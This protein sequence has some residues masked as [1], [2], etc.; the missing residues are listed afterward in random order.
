MPNQI[1][2]PIKLIILMT[3]T[4]MKRLMIVMP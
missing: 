2:I 1:K 3:L 4:I